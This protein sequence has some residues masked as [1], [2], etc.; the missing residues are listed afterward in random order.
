MVFYLCYCIYVTQLYIVIFLLVCDL[1]Y[2][3]Q[4]GYM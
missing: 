2:Y 3:M 1:L 4:Y